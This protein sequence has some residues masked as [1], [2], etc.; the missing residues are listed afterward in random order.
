L[1]SSDITIVDIFIHNDIEK[2]EQAIIGSLIKC[3]VRD[4][5]GGSYIEANHVS[6]VTAIEKTQ[7]A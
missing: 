1:K 4:M 6:A 2:R 3:L 5:L 7:S